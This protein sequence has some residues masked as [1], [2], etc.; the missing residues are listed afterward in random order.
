MSLTPPSGGIV[1]VEPLESRIAP[2]G[3]YGSNALL[4]GN[5]AAADLFTAVETVLQAKSD[6]EPEDDRRGE[7]T[8]DAMA[9]TKEADQ[10]A[11][12]Q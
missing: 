4:T 12:A 2:T 10:F 8:N 1:F 7:R 3:F 6:E 11:V 5:P 9:L